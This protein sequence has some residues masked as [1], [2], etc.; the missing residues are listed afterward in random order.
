MWRRLNRRKVSDWLTASEVISLPKLQRY[1]YH[2]SEYA[3]IWKE[4]ATAYWRFLYWH[5]VEGKNTHTHKTTKT[6]STIPIIQTMCLPISRT[7]VVH[8]IYYLNMDWTNSVQSL[9]RGKRFF[10][11]C[12][13]TGSRST[14]SP[15]SMG[16][17]QVKYS[18]G[19]TLTIHSRLV[20][21]SRMNRNI[22]PLAPTA[23]MACTGTALLLSPNVIMT[24]STWLV[25]L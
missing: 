10:L 25:Q 21:R 2:T 9:A 6:A 8:S 5:S 12:V 18:W 17:W 16:A 11:A 1:N 19:V 22:L 20:Q 3:R 4:M 7:K 14:I 23:S 15:Y 24:A 13:Q